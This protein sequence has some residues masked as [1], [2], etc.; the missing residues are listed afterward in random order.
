[1]KWKKN[2]INEDYKNKNK[3]TRYLGII[4]LIQKKHAYFCLEN[5]IKI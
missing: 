5:E 1:M 4:N 3:K 2:I